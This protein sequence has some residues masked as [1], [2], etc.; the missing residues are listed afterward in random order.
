MLDMLPVVVVLETVALTLVSLA[1]VAWAR[2]SRGRPT[3]AGASSPS[4]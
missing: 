3:T 4:P 1:V 2:S